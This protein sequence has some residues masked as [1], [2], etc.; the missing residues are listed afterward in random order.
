M[1]IKEYK[2]LHGSCR[3]YA[4][5]QGVSATC[6]SGCW[7]TDLSMGYGKGRS[8][9]PGISPSWSW[10]G[11]TWRVLTWADTHRWKSLCK[12]PGFLRRISML[13]SKLNQPKQTNQ[14]QPKSNQRKTKQNE[15]RHFGENKRN[16]A[17][18][19]PSHVGSTGW[20]NLWW[21]S[22]SSGRMK[23]K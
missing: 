5:C 11:S 1:F 12:S 13:C 2:C 8:L 23:E 6:A 18:A 14:T 21:L 16:F 9:C 10:L 22:L 3:M 7:Q 20:T 15:F 17:N 19:S 4:V